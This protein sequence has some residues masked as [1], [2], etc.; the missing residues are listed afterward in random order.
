MRTAAEADAQREQVARS[1]SQVQA[2]LE[3]CRTIDDVT[4]RIVDMLED[5]TLAMPK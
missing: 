4:E 5:I 1:E 3:L 2:I